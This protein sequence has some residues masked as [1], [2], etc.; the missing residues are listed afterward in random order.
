MCRRNFMSNVCHSR[1]KNISC[2]ERR[3][4][5]MKVAII[6]GASGGL[7]KALT[8]ALSETG[9]ALEFWLLGR[10]KAKLEITAQ[11]L[12]TKVRLLTLDLA[13]ASWEQTMQNILQN[14]HP[15]IAWLINNAG[16]GYFGNFSEEAK[17]HAGRMADVDFA[18]PIRLCALCLPYMAAGS[19][20]VNVCSVAG[21]LPLPQMA[22]Y[23]GAKAG[24]L[25]F[26]RA[27]AAELEPDGISVTALCPYWI[28][29]TGFIP[30]LGS[31]PHLNLW[32]TLPAEE[33]A[34]RGILGAKR[35]KAVVTP[36]FLATLCRIGTSLL[37]LPVLLKIRDIWKA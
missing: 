33:V 2:Q 14:E 23:S 24:L 21:F 22:V 36:G 11:K 27:L 37:P 13:D 10:D 12:G 5:N 20:I 16:F 29:N 35:G 6:T 8:K 17:Q 32:G 4:R 3:E 18:A 30:S 26:S 7:G 15:K 28:G 34:R 19:H 25:H 31:K 9:E 1:R